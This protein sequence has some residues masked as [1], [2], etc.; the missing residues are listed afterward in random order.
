MATVMAMGT[1]IQATVGAKLPSPSSA[2]ADCQEQVRQEIKGAFVDRPPIPACTCSTSI[3]R[4][5]LV[6]AVLV[7]R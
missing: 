4:A 1:S 7:V 3:Q 6:E 2:S 5:D